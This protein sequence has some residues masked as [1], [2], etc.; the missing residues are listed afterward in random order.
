MWYYSWIYYMTRINPTQMHVSGMRPQVKAGAPVNRHDGNEV[1][2]LLIDELNTRLGV[3]ALSGEA[4]K[5]EMAMNING[6]Y[7]CQGGACER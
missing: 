2:K 3:C 1:R 5:C 7:Y 4:P 6:R